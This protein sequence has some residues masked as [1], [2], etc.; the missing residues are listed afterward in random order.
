LIAWALRGDVLSRL[1]VAEVVTSR[2][3]PRQAGIDDDDGEDGGE[4]GDANRIHCRPGCFGWRGPRRIVTTSATTSRLRTSPRSANAIRLKCRF[5]T[6]A[7]ART[8]ASATVWLLR[9]NITTHS[10]KTIRL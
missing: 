1:V 9:V 4:Q 2:L 6:I 5:G 3:G 10:A 8:N 7:I